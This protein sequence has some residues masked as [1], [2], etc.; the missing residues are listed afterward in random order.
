LTRREEVLARLKSMSDPSQAASA[1]RFGVSAGNRMG[2]RVPDL[3]RLA[4]ELGKDHRMAL[5]LWET[6][7][8]EARMLAS[9]IGEPRELT[10]AQM[11]SWVEG[12]DAWDVCDQ[13]CMNLFARSPLAWQKVRD[14]AERP[15][16]YVKRAAFA[17]LACLAWHDRS[18]P[19]EQFI[20]FLPLIQAGASDNRHFVKKA[21]S[22]A[23]R[24]IGKRNQRLQVEALQFARKMEDAD[25]AVARWIGR[26]A[27]RDLTSEAAQRRAARSA[28]GT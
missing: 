26:D 21:V 19:D 13:A 28:R 11:D 6:G 2:I 8:P 4:K 1:A 5:E 15:E 7:V 14:W 23:L 20:E 3:R 17:L 24:N 22:W 16:E 25:S 9:M 27:V 12:F 10:A 18:S